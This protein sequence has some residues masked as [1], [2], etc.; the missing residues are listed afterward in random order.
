MTFGKDT[1]KRLEE[2]LGFELNRPEDKAFAAWF[3]RRTPDSLETVRFMLRDIEKYQPVPKE[4]R[5]ER[6]NMIPKGMGTSQI[7]L[8]SA[9]VSGL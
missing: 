8:E 1:M 3:E 7:G 4:K 5:K 2:V 6:P 9:E